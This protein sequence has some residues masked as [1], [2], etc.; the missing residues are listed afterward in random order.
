MPSSLLDKHHGKITNVVK[1]FPAV[2]SSKI[3][4]W[5]FRLPMWFVVCHFSSKIAT[6]R[7]LVYVKDV[8]A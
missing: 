5:K 4:P 6:C 2:R 3:V 1:G 8:H 7:Y